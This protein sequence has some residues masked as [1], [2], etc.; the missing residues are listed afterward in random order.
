RYPNG[1]NLNLRA[2]PDAGFAFGGWSGDVTGTNNPITVTVNSDKNVTA[3]FLDVSA[4]TVAILSPSAGTSTDDAIQL[5]G[6]VSDNVRVVSAR[7]EW[8][9]QAA[10]YLPLIENRFSV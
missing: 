2:I 6:T 1:T 10:G 4:P 7:W 9:G 8:N 5:S 3:R